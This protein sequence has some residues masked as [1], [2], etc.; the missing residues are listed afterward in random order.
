[1]IINAIKTNLELKAISI[2]LTQ[3][4]EII[5]VRDFVDNDRRW[6][7]NKGVFQ[8]RR[9]SSGRCAYFHATFVAIS[10]DAFMQSHAGG[11]VKIA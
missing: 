6:K 2:A 1:M 9:Y 7:K 5:D 3:F 8:E 4:R 10:C 11:G